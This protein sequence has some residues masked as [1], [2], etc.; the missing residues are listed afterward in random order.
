MANLKTLLRFL[1]ILA[2]NNMPK[3]EKRKKISTFHVQKN[4]A[5]L[6]IPTPHNFSYGPSIIQVQPTDVTF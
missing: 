5:S 6:K 1:R 2:K 3:E 4:L